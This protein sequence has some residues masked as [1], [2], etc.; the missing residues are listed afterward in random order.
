MSVLYSLRGGPFWTFALEVDGRRLERCVVVRE[1]VAYITLPDKDAARLVTC[2]A[3]Y[4]LGKLSA[5]RL[6]IRLE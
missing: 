2:L 1:G 3:P 4:F 6:E 5:R